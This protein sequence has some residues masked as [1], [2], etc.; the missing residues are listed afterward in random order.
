LNI[1]DTICNLQDTAKKI[2][3]VYPALQLEVSNDTILCNN[4][5]TPFNIIANSSGS[6]TNFTWATDIG[7]TNIINTGGLDSVIN[8]NPSVTTTYYV[9]AT[10]GWPLCDLID[11][12]QVLFLDDAITLMGDTTICRGDTLNLFADYTLGGVTTFDWSPNTY[13]YQENQNIAFATP[14]DS[15]Y[16]YLTA[17]INGC[18]FYDSVFVTV[19]YIDPL[20]VYA[21]ATPEEVPE[22]GT[23]TLM[24]FP[25]SSI[26]NYL[27]SPPNLVENSTLQTTTA[28]INNDQDFAVTL[29]RGVCSVSASVSVKKLEF[30]CGDV[31]VFVPNAF[32]PNNDDINDKVFV[33]GQN[34]ETIKFMIFDRWGEV[35]FETTDQ[36]IG[37]DGTFKDEKLDPDVYVYH[38]K[39]IC[40]D[41]Q[42]NLIKGNITL[43][44]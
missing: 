42:E 14:V 41:G 11:S 15:Q 12:V 20:S 18:P 6:A 30:V 22:G 26:Y 35:V 39:V 1:T 23:T 2:I 40:F 32:T 34:I 9:T 27:W 5:D 31:Y 43:L 21:T 38:L 7:F 37:W 3:N 4:A 8:V 24:A 36:N 17:T 29:T 19:D 33:R 28:T 44:R 16:Y 25:D 13:I 10:N